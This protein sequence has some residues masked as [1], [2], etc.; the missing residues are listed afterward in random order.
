MTNPDLIHNYRRYIYGEFDDT[1]ESLLKLSRFMDSFKIPGLPSLA[2]HEN[3]ST[4][5]VDWQC[6]VLENA[7]YSFS[8]R[9][10]NRQQQLHNRHCTER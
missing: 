3:E 7:E 9:K 2:S 5:G 8:K 1:G 10:C 4:K 6:E